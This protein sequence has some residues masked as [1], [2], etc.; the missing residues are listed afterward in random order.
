M[1]LPPEMSQCDFCS[2]PRTV[3]DEAGQTYYTIHRLAAELHDGTIMEDSGE[4]WACPVCKEL[5]NSGQFDSL[6]NRVINALLAQGIIKNSE[7][8][9]T[10]ARLK[11]IWELT[12]GMKAD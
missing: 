10:M 11:M 2:E 7:I 12:F 1:P 6:M 4:W 3:A 9:P 5:I 8:I